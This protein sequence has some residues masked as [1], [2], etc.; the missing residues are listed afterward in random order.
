MN[1]F[2]VALRIAACVACLLAHPTTC[3]AASDD[4]MQAALRHLVRS[5][6]LEQTWPAMLQATKGTGAEQIRKGVKDALDASTTDPVKRARVEAALARVAPAM[7]ADI[8]AA[9]DKLDVAA[10]MQGMVGAVYPKYYSAAEIEALSTFYESAVF[11]KLIAFA[12][13]AKREAQATGQNPELVW[14]RYEARLTP[15][16][17][18]YLAAFQ[19]SPLGR[20]QA[21]LQ[22]RVAQDGLRYL[23]E[24]TA[25]VLDEI[26]RRYARKVEQELQTSP[27]N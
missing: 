10:L 3:A 26:V 27:A 17:K 18:Q 16:D 12:P 11:R 19:A 14:A 2:F 6:N 20:K 21:G 8:D 15:A 23:Q 4:A 5:Q 22:A 7:A 24:R 9:H 1:R 25:P 13:L